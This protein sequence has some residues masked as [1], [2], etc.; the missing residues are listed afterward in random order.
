[1]FCRLCHSSVT[2]DA[3]GKQHTWRL[4]RMAKLSRVQCTCVV[5]IADERLMNR[6]LL[7][8]QVLGTVLGSICTQRF[9]GQPASKRNQ[10]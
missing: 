9:R 7:L 1:M 4:L 3:L 6:G 2:R 8:L 5:F 10:P